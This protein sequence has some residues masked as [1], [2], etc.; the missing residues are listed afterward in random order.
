MNLNADSKDCFG[1]DATVACCLLLRAMK[2][3]SRPVADGGETGPGYI[4]SILKVVI[5][6]NGIKKL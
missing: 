1:G 4:H 3:Q 2:R 6:V 5:H